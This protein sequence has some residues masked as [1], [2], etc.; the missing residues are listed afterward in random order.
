MGRIAKLLELSPLLLAL[1]F[2]WGC[3]SV[4]PGSGDKK[5]EKDEDK[6]EKSYFRHRWWNYYD[7]ALAYAEIQSHAKSVAD[8]EEA[9][10]QRDEDQRM[11]RTYG[12]HF[13]DYFPHRELGVVLYQMGELE[14]AETELEASLDQYPSAKAQFYLERVRKALIEE[15]GREITE[16]KLNLDFGTDPV[17]TSED[18]VVVSGLAEDEMYVAGIRINGASLF[19]D[20]SRKQIHFHR[21]LSL[22]QGQHLVSV[23]ARNLLGGATKKEVVVH[24][25]RQ[26]P[27]IIIEELEFS[28]GRARGEI[29]V[30]GFVHDE[31]GVSVLEVDGQAVSIEQGTDVPFTYRRAGEAGT[32]ALSAKDRLGNQ[33]NAKIPLTLDEAGRSPVRVAFAN[34]GGGGGYPLISLFGL[35]DTT[36]PKV[37]LEGWTDSQVVYLSKVYLEGRVSDAG[38]IASL[39]INQIPLLIRKG[40]MIFFSHFVEL[41]EGE[42]KVTIEAG[43]EAGN[44]AATGISITRKIPKALQLNERLSLSVL[45]MEQGGAVSDLSLFFQYCLIDELVDRNRFRVLAR[46]QLAEI[47]QEQ[48]LSQ[49][50]LINRSTALRLGKLAAVHAIVTGSMLETHTGIEIVCKMI[51][52]ETSEILATQDV[53][54]ENKDPAAL[55]ALAEAMAIK[56]H[57]DFP[58]VDGLV[59]D[60]KQKH[61]FT[62]LGKEEIRRQRRVLVYRETVLEHPVTKKPVGTDNEIIGRA[63]FTQVMPETSK[64][65]VLSGHE[66]KIQPMDRVITQ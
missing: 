37:S 12:M 42:N 3:A 29:T 58:L 20:G 39:S 52:T 18:P 26:G 16:P 35:G 51:D 2:V 46:E 48:K 25:D 40:R 59:I 54:D 15:E 53:Y 13:I 32:V 10:R 49:S 21:D 36:P 34:A 4:S 57:R 66:E 41:E 50:K 55:R 63:V 11:A 14:K 7:R 47:L 23:E 44:S 22:G 6:I 62:D 8:L 19:I 17:W 60:R 64:A 38:K 56:I 61:I 28:G 9:L 1:L 65:E 33:T 31:A 45:P 43:D 30:S 24:V 5:A 27:I